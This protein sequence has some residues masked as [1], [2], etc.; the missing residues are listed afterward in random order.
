[1]EP[2]CY[3]VEKHHERWLVSV[4]GAQVLICDTKKTALKVVRQATDALRLGRG[5]SAGQRMRSPP[6]HRPA[7]PAAPKS[8]N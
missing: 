8:S 2:S 3:S 4:C 5:T 6:G 1:M 7:K